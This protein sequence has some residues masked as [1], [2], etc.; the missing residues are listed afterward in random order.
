MATKKAGG[1]AKNLTDVNPQYLGIKLYGGQSA[2]VGSV[3][4]R[5]RGTRILPGKNVG[6][7]KDHT[8]FALKGGLVQYGHTRKRGFNEKVKVKKTVSVLEKK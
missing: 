1:T 5:Q 3:I 7:G 2:R 4:V 6:L 8:L